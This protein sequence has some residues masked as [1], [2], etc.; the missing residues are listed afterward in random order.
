MEETSGAEGALV[1]AVVVVD[2]V[3]VGLARVDLVI[4]EATLEVLEATMISAIMTPNVYI[5]DPRKEESLEAE[6]LPLW[7]VEANT[8]TNYET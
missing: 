7:W 6:A 1:A 3:A 8:L 2:V 4:M 5:L